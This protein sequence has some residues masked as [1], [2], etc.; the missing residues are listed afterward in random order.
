MKS[1]TCRDV[2]LKFCGQPKKNRINTIAPAIK[3]AEEY[4]ILGEEVKSFVRQRSSSFR[5]RQGSSKSTDDELP[6]K[7]APQNIQPPR[8]RVPL[9]LTLSHWDSVDQT[10]KPVHSK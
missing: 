8:K 2:I 1:P 10:C 7:S 6:A 4:N 9:A 3:M 5:S